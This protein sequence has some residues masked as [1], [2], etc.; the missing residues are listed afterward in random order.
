MGLPSAGP[1]TCRS[2]YTSQV[3]DA[4]GSGLGAPTLA[5]YYHEN[6]ESDNILMTIKCE[7]KQFKLKTWHWCMPTTNDDS[8][9]ASIK[10]VHRFMMIFADREINTQRHIQIIT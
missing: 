7:E 3:H 10:S 9:R 5:L 1:T 8:L 6:A 2:G 4:T